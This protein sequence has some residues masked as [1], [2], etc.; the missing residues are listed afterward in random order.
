MVNPIPTC[1]S[2]ERLGR[3]AELADAARLRAA[4]YPAPEPLPVQRR[5]RSRQHPSCRP[6]TWRTARSR[7][8]G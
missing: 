8:R 3:L 5:A 7:R 6:N 2:P 1:I 4:L